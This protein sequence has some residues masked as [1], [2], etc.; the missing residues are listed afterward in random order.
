M[1]EKQ[2]I[3]DTIKKIEQ[4]DPEFGFDKNSKCSWKYI[5]DWVYKKDQEV[6]KKRFLDQFYKVQEVIEG[7]QEKKP[8]KK[9]KKVKG[10]KRRQGLIKT[11]YDGNIQNIEVPSV[12][13]DKKVNFLTTEL[14][15]CENYSSHSHELSEICEKVYKEKENVKESL[16]TFLTEKI[17]DQIQ[18]NEAKPALNLS[19]FP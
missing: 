2:I 18:K 12:Q 3:K 19:E 15:S 13:D 6:F 9:F 10:L 16:K 17:Q 14:S 8:K 4:G 7:P 11:N 1:E 5:Y